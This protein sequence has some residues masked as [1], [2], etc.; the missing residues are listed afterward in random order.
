MR[1]DSRV[2]AW[3]VGRLTSPDGEP[4]VPS[5]C[6]SPRAGPLAVPV[7]Q[8]RTSSER[9][10]T[11]QDSLVVRV[12]VSSCAL[13]QVCPPQDKVTFRYGPQV[14]PAPGVA[15]SRCFYSRS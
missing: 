13:L 8:K 7:F 1:T 11:T 10:P 15:A 2:R 5:S 3:L 4:L 12:L 6:I 14:C 9:A